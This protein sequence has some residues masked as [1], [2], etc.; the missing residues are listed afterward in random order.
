MP[1]KKIQKLESILKLVDESVTRDEFVQS[2]ELV[3]KAVQDI[4]KSN[5]TEWTLIHSAM[6]M[7]EKKLRD[8]NDTNLG[9]VK[10]QLNTAIQ[11]HILRIQE[12]IDNVKDGVDGLPGRDGKD[13]RDGAD[14]KPADEDALVRKIELDLPKLGAATRDGLELLQGDDR[15]KATAISGLEEELAKMRD[16]IVGARSSG[17][18][19]AAGVQYALGNIVK[20][21]TPA[22]VIDG[23]NLAYTVTQPIHAV[24]SFS[25][26]GQAISDDLYT[27]AGRTITFITA[28]DSAL[29]GTSYRIVYV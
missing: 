9:S 27:I 3:L 20:N 2:F 19:S 6:Q 22:G 1:D 14:A 16:Q 18:T 13:G 8:S 25:I 23:V 5:E 29:S 26:N 10:E 4:K 24:F 11:S 28:I 21:E 15:L 7:L 12:K 17:G